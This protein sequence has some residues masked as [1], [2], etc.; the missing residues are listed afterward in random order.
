MGSPSAASLLTSPRELLIGSFLA[1]VAT[2]KANAVVPAH[3]PPPARGNTLVI[4]AGKAS[5]DMAACVENHWP[6][7]ARLGGLV[8]TRHGHGVPTHRIEVME[9][10]HP[11]PDSAG[12]AAAARV[13]ELVRAAGP[14]DR[15][16]ALVSGG[17]SSLLTLPAIGLELND[18]RAASDALL[19]SGAPIADINCVR[20]HL[21][22]TLGGRLAVECRAPVTVL[23]ISDVTGDDSSVIA[24]GP[25]APDPTTFAD[26][27][28]VLERW[29][30]KVPEPVRRYLKEGASGFHPDTPK[31][32]S[33]CFSRV[34]HRLI[35]NGRTALK[36]AA[37]YFRSHGITP[38]ILGD[39][40]TG[41]ARETAQVF[42]A[43][44]REIRLHGMPWNPPVAL[45]SGGETSVTVRGQG[46]GGRNAEFQLALAMALNGLDGVHALAADT[47][48]I[49]GTSD[50]AGAII[51][52][53][54]LE[55]AGRIGLSPFVCLAD[56]NAYHFFS[57]LDDLIHTGA[58]RTN[59]NDYRAILIA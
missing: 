31:P 15:V 46:R 56:N 32:G 13:L 28:A 48:G 27:L 14:D 58:T 54:S 23:M 7:S 40:V 12:L 3:L 1:A 11:L 37:D 43:L 24:S 6:G 29:R 51:A 2:V 34:E 9:A 25:F 18:V 39:S 47:D 45:L 26:G 50:S 49:D 33:D 30:V 8:I 20:K 42:A 19:N 4:G 41:E 17:G 22:Q 21:C 59:A 52:P 16:L 5:A 38:V 57:S 36:G 35:A 44:A 53:S 10:G 55:R